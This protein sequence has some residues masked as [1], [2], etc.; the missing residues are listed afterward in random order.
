L[1]VGIFYLIIQTISIY[2]GINELEAPQGINCDNIEKQYTGEYFLDA[3][4]L[5]WYQNIEGRTFLEITDDGSR[6]HFGVLSCF[7][8]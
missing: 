6:S 1:S 7:C 3:A 8:K 5:D 4:F 2:N